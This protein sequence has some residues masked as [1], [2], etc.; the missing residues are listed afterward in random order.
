VNTKAYKT[1]RQF[2][3]KEKSLEKTHYRIFIGLALFA[4][5]YHYFF[6]AKTIGHDI[7]YNIFIFWLP[8]LIGTLA[9]G[10]YRRKFILSKFL[11]NRGFSLWTFMAVFYLLQGFIFSY[12]SFGQV[13]KI[14]WDIAN[15][16]TANENPS[17]TL[18][19]NVTRFWSK[20]RPYAIEFNLNGKYEKINVDYQTLKSYIDESPKE[21]EIY[22]KAQR[23]LWN[24]YF[25]KNW[26]LSKK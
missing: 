24:H 4:C 16:Q 10:I 19:C 7:R 23:G 20:R 6:Q 11:T 21:Y 26:T 2:A 1:K 15:R 8:T 17:E 14:G 3:Q 9:I 22:I 18:I 13:A 12:L 5:G 25:V